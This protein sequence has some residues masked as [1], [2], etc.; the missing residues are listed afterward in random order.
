MLCMCC[1][2]GVQETHQQMEYA[3]VTRKFQLQ[4]EPRHRCETLLHP[5]LYFM[6]TFSYLIGHRDLK[7]NVRLMVRHEPSVCGLSVRRLSR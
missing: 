6:V 5:I 1:E 2:K 7:P 3:K 4:P